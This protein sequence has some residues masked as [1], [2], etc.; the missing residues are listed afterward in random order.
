MGLDARQGRPRPGLLRRA[1][2]ARRL[3]PARRPVAPRRRVEG[4]AAALAAYIQARR[5]VEDER[6]LRL[7]DLAE[8]GGARAS[9][10]RSADRG[11]E[12]GRDFPELPADFYNFSGLFGQR[13]TVFPTQDIVI[14]RIGQDPGLVPAGGR[15]AGRTSCT[16]ACSRR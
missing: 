1:H 13:V 4:P 10:R 7:A 2:D 6:L 16:S 11:V 5:A 9:A 12:D 8:R 15:R 3:R 14:V